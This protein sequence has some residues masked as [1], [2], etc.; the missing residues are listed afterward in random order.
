MVSSPTGVRRRKANAPVVGWK[1]MEE[2]M[3]EVSAVILGI[4]V[5]MRAEARWTAE[6][7]A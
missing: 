6:E 7:V 3:D 4:G 2:S 5:S 1:A